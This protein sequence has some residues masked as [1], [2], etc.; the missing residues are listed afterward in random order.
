MRKVQPI[1][2][3]RVIDG[4]KEYFYIR[5]MR[6]Y[7]FFCMGIYSGLRVSDLL[8]L[9]AWQT[10]GTHISMVEQK[11]SMRRLLLSIRV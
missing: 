3:E 10:K 6:N 2:D 9:K 7:L 5:S 8:E 11:I 1:R 4:M